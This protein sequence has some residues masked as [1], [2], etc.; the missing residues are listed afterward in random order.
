MISPELD[1]LEQLL[2][3]ELSLHAVSSIYLF[4][5]LDHARRVVTGYC[6]SGV[7]RL[8]DSSEPDG[9]IVEYRVRSILAD[10][11]SWQPQSVYRIEITERGLAHLAESG[12]C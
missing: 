1:L 10:E 2:G 3:G 6:D 7:V 4:R 8:Y 5:D 11:A 9:S 12:H